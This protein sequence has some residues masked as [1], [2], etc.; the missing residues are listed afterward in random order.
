MTGSVSSVNAAADN[1]FHAGCARA[2]REQQRIN[3][4]ARDDPERIWRLHSAGESA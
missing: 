2:F 1:L 4:I 3:A